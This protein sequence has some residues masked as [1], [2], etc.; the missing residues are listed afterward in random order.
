MS[1]FKDVAVCALQQ[2][3]APC[4][5][6]LN[7]TTL[8]FGYPSVAKGGKGVEDLLE[9]VLHNFEC[10]LAA[11]LTILLQPAMQGAGCSNASCDTPSPSLGH[12]I[13]WHEQLCLLPSILTGPRRGQQARPAV[14][15]QLKHNRRPQSP[16]PHGSN[17]TGALR[18]ETRVQT[19][20]ATRLR[21]KSART[22]GKRRSCE[23]G[24]G[25]NSV[26]VSQARQTAT[27]SQGYRACTA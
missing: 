9:L 14:A 27:L 11:V 8:L 19:D 18:T 17:C 26:S 4:A 25:R 12:V 13:F 21:A 22:P 5:V 16:Y 3:A 6:H 10:L 15:H 20:E 2:L 24:R 1:I 7:G 23:P